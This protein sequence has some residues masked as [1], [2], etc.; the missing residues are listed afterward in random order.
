MD[1]SA[2][3]RSA[4]VVGASGLVGRELTRH[5]LKTADY[6]SVHVAVRKK[7][8]I[9]HHKLSEHIVDFDRFDEFSPQARITDVYI[10]L[11]TTR[12]KAGSKEKFRKVDFDY[13]KAVGEWAKKH[14]CMSL[15]FVSSIG[16]DASSKMLY[17]QTKG[18]AENALAA[19]LLPNLIVVRPS[20]LL[21][22]RK[23]FRLGEV[24][25]KFLMH[26]KAFW[27]S[28]RFEKYRAIEGKQVAKAMIGFVFGNPGGV[29]II[30]ND[31]LRRS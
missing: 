13:V 26:P 27:L 7:Y 16:A 19:L 18:Q 24:I 29:N 12:K 28:G 22:E 1:K 8:D 5:L 23:E 10:C 20:L 3:V 30:E 11:G 6:N 2:K 25:G 9:E 31:T 21:G 14:G 17:P 15:A 4:L